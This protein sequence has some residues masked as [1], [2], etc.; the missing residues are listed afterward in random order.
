MGQKLGAKDYTD[1]K[2]QAE[3][4]DDAAFKAIKKDEKTLMKA[5]EGLTDA[6]IKAL[7]TYVRTFK[8]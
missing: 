3:M 6:D 4:K 5:A 7:V 8:K 2:V 1:A